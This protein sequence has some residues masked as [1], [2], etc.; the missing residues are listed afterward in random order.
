MNVTKKVKQL[1]EADFADISKETVREYPQVGC[2]IDRPKSLNVKEA[3][4]NTSHRIVAQD[5][6]CYYVKFNLR[7]GK[8]FW[9]RFKSSHENGFIF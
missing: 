8:G 7:T 9:F 5:G 1:T 3:G 6:W 4:D 2:T